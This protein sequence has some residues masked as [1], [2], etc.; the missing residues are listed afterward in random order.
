M[1][2]IGRS[3]LVVAVL[4]CSSCEPPPYDPQPGER[5]WSMLVAEQWTRD[6][7]LPPYFLNVD[8]GVLTSDQPGGS[9]Y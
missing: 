7:G 9:V 6:D 2:R 8:V 5:F 3:G 4:L 1:T